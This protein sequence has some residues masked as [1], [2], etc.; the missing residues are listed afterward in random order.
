MD[1]IYDIPLCTINAKAKLPIK[2]ATSLLKYVISSSQYS[3]ALPVAKLS[4]KV[5]ITNIIYAINAII[6]LLDNFTTIFIL[7]INNKGI[8]NGEIHKAK[9]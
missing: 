3:Y 5:Y 2:L 7:R 4:I 1:I 8:T 9:Y 6:P